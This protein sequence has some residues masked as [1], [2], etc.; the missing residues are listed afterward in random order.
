MIARVRPLAGMGPHVFLQVITFGESLATFLAQVRLLL[1]M[2]SG[3]SL[4]I[5]ATCEAARTMLALVR[6]GARVTSKMDT[7][8]AR[9]TKGG[10]TFTA[11]EWPFATVGALEG[12][13]STSSGEGLVTLVTFVGPRASVRA[14]VRLKIAFMCE[15]LLAH[16]TL[17][18]LSTRMGQNVIF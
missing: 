10:I 2:G 6:F 17:K 1:C 14:K 7:K 13:Q 3:V 11:L 9:L 5:G 4:Q 18:W 12:G 16:F 8:A 15:S